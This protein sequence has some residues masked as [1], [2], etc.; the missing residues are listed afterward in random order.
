MF[1][2]LFNKH[3]CYL[4]YHENKASFIMRYKRANT[5]FGPRTSSLSTFNS[6]IGYQRGEGFGS[7]FKTIFKNVTPFAK[8][9]MGGTKNLVKSALNSNIAKQAGK[10]LLNQGIE[11]SANILGDIIEGENVKD[12]VKNNL[13]TA[14]QNI[15]R[16]LKSTVKSGLKRKA[17][18]INATMPIAKKRKSTQR[19]NIRFA[20]K[21]K[22]RNKS[23][24]NLFE[25]NDIQ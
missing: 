3:F 6:P 19:K 8:R 24:Y 23:A 20:P 4:H 10:E 18:N 25:D 16:T 12:S 9:M 5:L 17:D 21:V 22:K 15:A 1:V 14:K 2:T 11:T 7:F 13:K